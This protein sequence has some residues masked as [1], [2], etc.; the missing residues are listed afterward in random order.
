MTVPA[1]PHSVCWRFPGS[2]LCSER[3][4]VVC[5]IGLVWFHTQH[6]PLS[7]LSS[8]DGT[9]MLPSLE[10]S[11]PGHCTCQVGA[12]GKGMPP[13][14]LVTSSSVGPGVSWEEGKRD[15]A[16]R[17]HA[18]LHLPAAPQAT[19]GLRPQMCPRPLSP[20]SPRS[21]ESCPC[22]SQRAGTP[23]YI[24]IITSALEP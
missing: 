21:P 23:R 6:C 22:S 18:G 9:H 2:L 19:S 15:R 17:F 7:V 16:G 5:S 14:A 11:C 13:Q 20:G 3:L 8:P 10:N 4:L 1:C 12:S 24:Q